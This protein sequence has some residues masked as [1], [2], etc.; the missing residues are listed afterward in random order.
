LKSEIAPL[1]RFNEDNTSEDKPSKNLTEIKKI[2]S[3]N[4]IPNQRINGN[5]A[6]YKQPSVAAGGGGN[7][8]GSDGGDSYESSFQKRRN[9]RGGEEEELNLNIEEDMQRSMQD[10]PDSIKAVLLDHEDFAKSIRKGVKYTD[11]VNTERCDEI[12]NLFGEAYFEAYKTEDGTY[13]AL[14]ETNKFKNT[15]VPKARGIEALLNEIS[16]VGKITAAEPGTKAYALACE[17]WEVFIKKIKNLNKN[18]SEKV[19]IKILIQQ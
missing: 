19:N 1:K 4:R 6:R 10:I 15:V 12:D 2:P 9:R 18:I 16:P 11:V 13:Q 5:S 8:E 3:R 7:A 17:A 14:L